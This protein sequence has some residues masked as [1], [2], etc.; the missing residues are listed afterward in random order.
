MSFNSGDFWTELESVKDEIEDRIK[1]ATDESIVSLQ[2]FVEKVKI[3]ENDCKSLKEK[4]TEL[5]NENKKLK[6]TLELRDRRITAFNKLYNY[7]NK[8]IA[9]LESKNNNLLQK[10]KKKKRKSMKYII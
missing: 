2:V 9:D 7:L 4:T 10:L 8:Q 1:L 3:L 5:E 6:Q